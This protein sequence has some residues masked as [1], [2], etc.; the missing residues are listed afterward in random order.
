MNCM[1]STK[2]VALRQH[3]LIIRWQSLFVR[4]SRDLAIA[5]TKRNRP[6]NA[7]SG[8]SSLSLLHQLTLIWIDTCDAFFLVAPADFPHSG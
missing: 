1:N 8:E 4:Q 6:Q 2:S 3:T 7:M 5:V